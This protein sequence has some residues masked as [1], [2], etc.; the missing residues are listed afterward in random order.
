M[1][2]KTQ[3]RYKMKILHRWF[4]D[5]LRTHEKYQTDGTCT[6]D[7]RSTVRRTVRTPSKH[8]RFVCLKY[9]NCIVQVENRRTQ[10]LFAAR[11][12]NVHTRPPGKK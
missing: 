12:S 7:E 8:Q 9:Y 1:K 5:Y 11:R 2:M 4:S 10:H 3:Q 6:R